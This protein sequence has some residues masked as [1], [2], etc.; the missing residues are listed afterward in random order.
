MMAVVSCLPLLSQRSCSWIVNS[1]IR[2]TS[3]VSWVTAAF[4]ET[5]MDTHFT[6]RAAIIG[7]VTSPGVGDGTGTS[8]TGGVVVAPTTGGTVGLLSIT[9]SSSTLT[10]SRAL[11]EEIT[12]TAH[13]VSSGP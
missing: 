9:A 6:P 3:P 10:T 1:I 4:G 8:A 7:E 12:N 11:I 5:M 2:L 13:V